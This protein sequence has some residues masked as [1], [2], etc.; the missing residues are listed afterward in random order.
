MKNKIYLNVPQDLNTNIIHRKRRSAD[1]EE[2][3]ETSQIR[4]YEFYQPRTPPLVVHNPKEALE[5][6]DL[7]NDT[8]F[9]EKLKASIPKLK[10]GEKDDVEL[11][12]NN[13]A[14]ESLTDDESDESDKSD[15]S[16]GADESDE[17]N[18]EDESDES[19]GNEEKDSESDKSSLTAEEPNTNKDIE[20]VQNPDRVL[21]EVEKAFHNN[22]RYIEKQQDEAN[23]DDGSEEQKI[24]KPMLKTN[25][26]ER[27]FDSTGDL[28]RE[29][30][31]LVEK[32]KTEPDDGNHYWKIE[33]ENPIV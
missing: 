32:K 20:F 1:D 9:Y 2:D 5:A 24:K 3:Q 12:K 14:G 33:Y 29:V 19:D 18:D 21:K 28:L 16:D 4:V 25:H 17:S 27:E 11:I 8:F 13:K 22:N 10:E 6:K 7:A 26:F 30:H 23:N 31:T 15:E